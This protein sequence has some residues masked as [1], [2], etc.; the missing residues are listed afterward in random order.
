MTKWIMQILVSEI[1][2]PIVGH[3]EVKAKKHA[4]AL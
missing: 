3:N 1:G 4:D 2:F